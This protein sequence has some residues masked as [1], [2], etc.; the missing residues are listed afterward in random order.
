M[1]EKSN[2]EEGIISDPSQNH[3]SVLQ[4]LNVANLSLGN[5]GNDNKVS[6]INIFVYATK[7][8]YYVYKGRLLPP[9]WLLNHTFYLHS[10]CII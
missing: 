2:L 6:M 3:D 1:S 9:R 5:V 10:T 4:D 7:L 8:C